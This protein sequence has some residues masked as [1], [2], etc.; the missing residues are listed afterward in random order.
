[1]TFLFRFILVFVGGN[2]HF[3]HYL[4]NYCVTAIKKRGADVESAPR[5]T[6]RAPNAYNCKL[7]Y[8]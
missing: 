1:M 5:Y 8:P 7:I 2:E 4:C 3:Q 6:G